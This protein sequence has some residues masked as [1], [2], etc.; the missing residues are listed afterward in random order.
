MNPTVLWVIVS[1]V[2]GTNSERLGSDTP[3]TIVA[4]SRSSAL[5]RF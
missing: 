1:K 2:L 3:S 5:M 4:V